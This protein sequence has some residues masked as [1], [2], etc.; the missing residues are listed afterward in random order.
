MMKKNG[1]GI[2]NALVRA[3]VDFLKET[4]LIYK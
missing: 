2:S 1:R 4:E 3:K